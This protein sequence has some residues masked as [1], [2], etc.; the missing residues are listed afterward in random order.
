[1]EQKPLA[2]NNFIT[3]QSCETC[4]VS[5]LDGLGVIWDP[6]GDGTRVDFSYNLQTTVSVRRGMI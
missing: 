6:R 3:Y 5:K 1:M 4:D 2:W